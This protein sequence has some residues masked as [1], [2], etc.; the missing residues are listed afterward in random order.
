[1]IDETDFS[2]SLSQKK[3]SVREK[4]ERLMRYNE[5]LKGGPLSYI[6]DDDGC[7]LTDSIPFEIENIE[8]IKKSPT[9]EEF[10][11]ARRT[12]ERMINHPNQ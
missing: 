10:H 6:S 2:L 1:M 9:I 3:E 4:S 12:L 7:E 8:N 5:K 11:H